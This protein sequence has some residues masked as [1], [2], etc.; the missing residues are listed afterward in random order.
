MGKSITW[1][2]IR[3]PPVINTHSLALSSPDSSHWNLI[4]VIKGMQVHPPKEIALLTCLFFKIS[5]TH[6]SHKLQIHLMARIF[7]SR[8]GNRSRSEFLHAYP[9]SRS[10][11]VKGHTRPHKPIFDDFSWESYSAQKSYSAQACSNL[12][13]ESI[14][15]VSADLCI[16]MKQRNFSQNL[17]RN[18]MRH[19]ELYPGS[20]MN[21]LRRARW[22]PKLKT[23]G[24][25]QNQKRIHEL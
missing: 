4:W 9:G 22:L 23:V 21:K 7:I 11:L 1:H 19:G 13:L 10:Q 17:K 14:M 20:Q 8:A 5:P 12:C 2:T 6:T 3:C 16:L 24:W 18:Q 15:L 25:L